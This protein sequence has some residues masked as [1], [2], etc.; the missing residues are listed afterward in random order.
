MT[1]ATRKFDDSVATA[2][3]VL[4]DLREEVRRT[5]LDDPDEWPVYGSLISD[6]L[7][8]V[9][10][11]ESARESAVVPTDSG[12]LRLP[13]NRSSAWARMRRL[14]ARRVA[15]RRADVGEEPARRG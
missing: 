3:T 4:T 1:R 6:S 9:R 14:G 11:L 5:P 7:R 13:P 8:A 10:E 15:T 2:L 12:P